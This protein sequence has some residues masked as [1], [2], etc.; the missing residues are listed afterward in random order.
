MADHFPSGRGPS[1]ALTPAAV[2]VLGND[3]V[4]RRAR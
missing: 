4:Y 2:F 1:I 3:T